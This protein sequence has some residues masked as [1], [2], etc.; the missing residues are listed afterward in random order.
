MIPAKAL[1]ILAVSYSAAAAA[2][3]KRAHV[4][5]CADPTNNELIT[6]EFGNAMNMASIASQYIAQNGA[7]PLFVSYFMTNDPVAVKTKYD[8]IVSDVGPADIYCQPFPAGR[9]VNCSG[10]NALT[11]TPSGN[12]YLCP[13]WYNLADQSALCTQSGLA[14]TRS[15]TIVHEMSHAEAGTHDHNGSCSGSKTLSPADALENATTYSCFAR[16]VYKKTQC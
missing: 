9:N 16:E 3:D 1:I 14:S 5:S 12:I 7:D 10:L 2:L 13:S 6:Q 15:G 11:R 8:Q 4:V